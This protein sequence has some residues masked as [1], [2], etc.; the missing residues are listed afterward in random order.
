M[1][2]RRAIRTPTCFIC[3]GG[4][5]TTRR[6]MQSPDNEA[7]QALYNQAIALDPGFALAHARRGAVLAFSSIAFAGPDK[8]LEAVGRC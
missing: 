8:D 4:N 6:D 7:A 5:S 1:T 3:E 2:N